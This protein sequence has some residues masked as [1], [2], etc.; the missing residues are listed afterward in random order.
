MSRALTLAVP[1]SEAFAESAQDLAIFNFVP[2]G[3]DVV[4]LGGMVAIFDRDTLCRE[5]ITEGAYYVRERQRPRAGILWSNWLALE[6]R[7]A[8]PRFGP[9]SPLQIEREVVR[10]VR[11][12]RG[13]QWALQSA[14]GYT[15][16]PFHDWA[17]GHDVIGKVIG[18]YQP[19]RER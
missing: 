10:A 18:L 15:D 5:E 1:E 7:D 8:T 6:A 9:A 2:S 12:R 17:F 4:P 3:C 13:D 14:E 11:W 19:K 16:G